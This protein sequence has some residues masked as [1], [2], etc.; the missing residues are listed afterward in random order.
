MTRTT[1]YPHVYDWQYPLVEKWGGFLQNTGGNDPLDLLNDLQNRD[2]IHFA[3]T[4]IV[5][6]TLAA[7]VG[8]QLTLLAR[9][10]TAGLLP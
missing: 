9:L 10:E 8:A 3:A 2:N 1:A 5:R 7:S 4:N 6:F